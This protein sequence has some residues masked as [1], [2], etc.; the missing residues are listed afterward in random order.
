M[1][2]LGV[3]GVCLVS[4]IRTSCFYPR[5]FMPINP[6]VCPSHYQTPRQPVLSPPS[7]THA[8]LPVAHI[9]A[10]EE[11]LVEARVEGR[12]FHA[13][14]AL[15]VERR[16]THFDQRVARARVTVSESAWAREWARKQFSKWK[17]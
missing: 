8:H 12:R 15:H 16:E 6:T 3:V 10:E 2:V 9:D 17:K 1:H 14:R 5:P 4:P 7:R 11:R 13:R